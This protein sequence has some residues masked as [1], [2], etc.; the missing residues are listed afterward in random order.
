MPASGKQCMD[1]FF[2]HLVCGCI[3]MCGGQLFYMGGVAE[4]V[5]V[6]GMKLLQM[7][8]CI[9]ALLWLN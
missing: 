1:L 5:A 6:K 4:E 9:W 8:N 3:C 7:L 2:C